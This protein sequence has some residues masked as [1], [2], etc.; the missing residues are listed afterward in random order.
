MKKVKINAIN[1]KLLINQPPA[2]IIQPKQTIPN[3]SAINKPITKHLFHS[4]HFLPITPPNPDN[5]SQSAPTH[6]STPNNNTQSPK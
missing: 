1:K 5:S 4:Q 3:Q 2:L 6:K